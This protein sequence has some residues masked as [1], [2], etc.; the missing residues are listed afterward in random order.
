MYFWN[1]TKLASDLKE[2]SVPERDKRN[3]LI[4]IGVLGSLSTYAWP[5]L[6]IEANEL[7][8]IEAAVS[9]LVLVIGIAICHDVNDD[10]DGK[11]FLDRFICMILPLAIRIT[12]LMIAIA[13][14]LGIVAAIVA[15]DAFERYTESTSYTGLDV[16]MT[17]GFEV[18]F[19]WRLKLHMAR[20]AGAAAGPDAPTA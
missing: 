19:F 14:P 16:L 5:S 3:Y 6:G 18:V 17:V 4:A 7:M 1:T 15:P 9:L 12:V 20:I 2:G 10:G 11:A 13:I 8:L